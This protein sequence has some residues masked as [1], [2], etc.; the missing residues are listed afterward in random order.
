MVGIVR[1]GLSTGSAYFSKIPISIFLPVLLS[2]TPQIKNSCQI[3]PT[4]VNIFFSNHA[5]P[6]SQTLNEEL[7][8][9]E[10]SLELP[11]I[12]GLIHLVRM[13]NFPQN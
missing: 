7:C 10:L 5:T 4:C 2:L 1:Y 3:N 9:I 8:Q 12:K 13:Q 6:A 11:V